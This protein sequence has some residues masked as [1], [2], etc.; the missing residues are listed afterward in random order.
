MNF[1]CKRKW[2]IL[3]VF[4]FLYPFYCPLIYQLTG[5]SLGELYTFD[6]PRNEFMIIWIVLGGIIGVVSN[7]RLSKKF[8]RH[9]VKELC[10]NCFSSGVDLLGNP[11]EY[12]RISGAYNL[13]FLAGEH[14]KEYLESVCEVLCTHI[15]TITNKLE[16]KIK[17]SDEPSMEIQTIL[18]LLFKE[19]KDELI[20][21]KC[22]KNLSRVSLNGA[23]FRK[24]I[25]NNVNF[26]NT[27][28]NDVQFNDAT[29]S[30]V[31]FMS[32]TL[33]NVDLWDAKLSNINFR[34]ATLGNIHFNSAQLC[35]IVFRDATL[36]DV[37]FR[38]ATFSDV[39][40]WYAKLEDKVI[41][42]GTSLE[43]IPPEEITLAGKLH[44]NQK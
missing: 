33:S 5:F 43:N 41:F 31:D 18:N 15:Q 21:D 16:Y 6:M 22:K 17:Y 8:M 42:T 27:I 40:F 30:N 35:R 3:G 19:D 13:Y 24:A 29:L 25:L 2:W 10:V 34:N 11:N 26:I 28:L 12:T 32:A 14:K 7:V 4:I 37:D 23:D 39:N 44:F 36:C 38:D 20:F 9:Q 1:L